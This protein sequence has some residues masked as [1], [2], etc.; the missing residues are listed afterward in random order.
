MKRADALWSKIVR[1]R[2]GNKCELCGGQTMLQAHHMITKGCCGFLRYSL[3]N[4]MCL[5]QG[6][7]YTFHNKDS[8]TAWEAFLL[9]RPADYYYIKEH[10]YKEC[11]KKTIGYYRDIIDWLTEVV[12]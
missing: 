2:A 6:C 7:H 12:A 10:K 4:G 5:C 9:S 8:Q 11:P 1:D 3:E